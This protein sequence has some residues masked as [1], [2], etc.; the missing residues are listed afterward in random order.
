MCPFR[1]IAF[2]VLLIFSLSCNKSNEKGITTDG[3]I[4][5]QHSLTPVFLSK[6]PGFENLELF[7]LL[8]SED[9]LAESPTYTFGGTADGQ[10][11]L[12][13]PDG[14]YTFIVNHEENWAIS[15]ITLDKTFKPQKGEYLLNSDGALSKLCSGTLATVAEHGFGP[16]FLSAAESDVESLSHAIDPFATP[17]PS[18]PKHVLAFGRWSAENEVP[19]PKTSYPGKTVIIIS[20]DA[21]DQSGGQV[22]MYI[23]NT[24]GDLNNGSL[25]FLRRTDLNIRERDIVI[26]NSYDVEFVQIM[27]QKTI[28]GAQIQ[29]IVM[30]NNGIRFSKVE[31]VDYRKGG[32]ANG[33]QIYFNASGQEKSGFNNDFSRTFKGRTYQ[34]TLNVDNPLKGKLECILDGDNVS[35]AA[36]NL[37]QNPDN[38]CVTTNYVYILEDANIYGDETHDGYIYQYDIKNKTLKPALEIKKTASYHTNGTSFNILGDWETS[39]LIDIS[40]VIGIPNTFTVSVQSHSWLNDRFKNPDGGSKRPDEKEGSQIVVIKGLQR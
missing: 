4:L 20:E 28:T 39:G 6:K 38:I 10:A 15:R 35:S 32:A 22:A 18:V 23:S 36:Y 17:T 30:D 13:S 25:Y 34:L 16:I 19:L 29:Q 31:D 33:R 9:E 5:K 40:D 1:P 3:I 21:G 27:N 2:S 37:F 8:S 14:G 26:G 24:P 11:L 12:K 7:T